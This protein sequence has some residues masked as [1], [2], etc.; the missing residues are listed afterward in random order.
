MRC[1]ALSIAALALTACGGSQSSSTVG[2]ASEASTAGKA[3]EVD[4]PQGVLA[5]ARQVRE[6]I[7]AEGGETTVGEWRIGYIIEGAEPWYEPQGK[8][9]IFRQP[10]AGET[11]HIEIVPIEE[12]TGRTVPG[13]KIT[14]QVIDSTGKTVETKPLNFY[15]AEFFH[16]ANNFSI[17]ASG[18]YTLR[19]TIEPPQFFRHGQHHEQPAL[20][21]GATA[22]F[23]DV[24]IDLTK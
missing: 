12:K 11:H 15:Y 23:E 10:A 3:S 16:Y 14:L 24:H 18:R 22:M 6:E 1:I 21:K 5:D 20:T 7:R 4:V 19:A 17:P 8:A 13:A 9:Y 2:N